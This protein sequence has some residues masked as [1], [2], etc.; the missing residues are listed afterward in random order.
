M[1]TL[2]KVCALFF[3]CIWLACCYL[4]AKTCRPRCSLFKP[5]YYYQLTK[6]SLCSL[7]SSFPLNCC[8]PVGSPEQRRWLHCWSV[9]RKIFHHSCAINS[10]IKH[11]S[12]HASDFHKIMRALQGPNHRLSTGMSNSSAAIKSNQFICPHEGNTPFCHFEENFLF[13]IHLVLW[14]VT[15]GLLPS[16]LV[17]WL[18]GHVLKIG[19]NFPEQFD[20]GWRPRFKKKKVFSNINPLF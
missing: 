10:L 13:V 9:G 6:N 14:L 12:S 8:F 18:Q 4:A 5:D 3:Y 15:P 20:Y 16:R 1:L 2:V 11:W 7:S 17:E 19:S